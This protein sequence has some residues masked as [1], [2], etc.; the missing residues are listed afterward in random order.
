MAISILHNFASLNLGGAESR[1]MDVYRAIDREQFHFDFVVYE[2]SEQHYEKEIRSLGGSVYRIPSPRQN[3]VRH[4]LALSSL[5]KR[6]KYD[7]IHSHTS[8]HSGLVS[9]IGWVHKVPIRIAHA[10]TSGSMSTTGLAGN[11]NRRV[12]QALINRFASKRLAISVASGDFVFGEFSDYQVLPNAFDLSRYDISFSKQEARARLGLP[13]N[14]IIIG[15]V[16]RLTKVKNQQFSIRL[17]KNLQKIHPDAMLI[18][19]G[20]G[21]DRKSL[22]DLVRFNDL[23]NSIIFVGIQANIPEWMLTF[24]VLL[25]PSIYEGLGVVVLEA[26]AAGTPVVAS[27]GV[28]Q[29]AD[30]GLSIASFLSLG[31]QDHHWLTAIEQ[32]INLERPNWQEINRAFSDRSFTLDVAVEEL[33]KIYRGE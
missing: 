29:F 2:D 13:E 24:D 10:R 30:I 27:T 7:A 28:P 32:L 19:V 9:F 21:P 11:L 20:E 12:G 5:I 23:E 25:M 15:Q 1:T 17:L 33:S 18:L 4:I 31:D 6:N 8:Y 3:I 16:G 14:R 26:Q 22:E